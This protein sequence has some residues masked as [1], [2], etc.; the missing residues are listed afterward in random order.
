M[1]GIGRREFEREKGP[2]GG[3]VQKGDCF[4]YFTV[5]KVLY[6]MV[7]G[8]RL[9]CGLYEQHVWFVFDHAHI[10]TKCSEKRRGP[11]MKH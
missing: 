6:S 11:K 9:L 2:K 3:N 8:L 10:D 5:Y 4:L 7:D 1:L